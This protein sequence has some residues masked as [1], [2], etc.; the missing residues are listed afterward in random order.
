VEFEP[1]GES[2]GR[3]IVTLGIAQVQDAG[4]EVLL[5]RQIS[6]EAGHVDIDETLAKVVR[7]R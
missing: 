5:P 3:G 4:A 6:R 1:G 2:G 7:D